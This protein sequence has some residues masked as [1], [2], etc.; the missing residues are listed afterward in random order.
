M[1]LA[2]DIGGTKTEL[3]VFS[4]EA[5]LRTPLAQARYPSA[6]YPSL[7]ALVREFLAT[8]VLPVT[9][10]CFG[11]AGPVIGERARITNLSWQL[12]A[13]ALASALGLRAV[14]LLNDLEAVARAVPELRSE[15]MVTLNSGACVADGS[16]AVIAPG[17]GLGE[18]FL[19]W[20]GSRH[21]AFPS[22]GGHADFAP[23]TERETGLLSHLRDRFGH[24][25]VERVCSGPGIVNIYEYLRAG[26]APAEA[27]EVA[28]R[29][30]AAP[31]APPVITEAGLRESDP[32][33]LSAATLALF[34]DILGA[35]AGNLALK[36]FASGGV[37][38]AGGVARHLLP[39]LRRGGFMQAFIRK[40]R[41]GDVM[42][43]MPVH[44]IV[45]PA[46][47]LGA[48]IR[49]LA[50]GAESTPKAGGT[51]TAGTAGATR[52]RH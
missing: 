25:S 31:D 44:V 32:D 10:A 12:D 34:S 41:M 38:V 30:G 4:P 51:Q 45:R 26:G 9:W 22:E 42:V 6:R 8:T 50:L 49:G 21:Q 18:A 14:H 47:I 43:R 11:V 23:A 39:M 28:R 7:E 24:V 29:L 3:A 36:V 37:Y 40:G 5:G 19:T 35:E 33:P 2:G 46:A 15:D 20:D 1:L 48:A 52:R 27:P 17:T 16:I 13:G